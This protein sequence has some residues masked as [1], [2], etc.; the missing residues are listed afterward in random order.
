MGFPRAHY[1]LGLLTFLNPF[2]LIQRPKPI[3]NS[4]TPTQALPDSTLIHPKY[5][6]QP[7]RIAHLHPPIPS[8]YSPTPLP[9][10]PP[11]SP[12]IN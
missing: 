3:V 5:L 9:S 1:L 4:I 2:L 8:V 12:M 7:V 10:S 6:H 11:F